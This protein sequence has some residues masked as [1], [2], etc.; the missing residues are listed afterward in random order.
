MG[1]KYNIHTIQ[2]K[3]TKR[4]GVN[5]HVPITTRSKT[6]WDHAP[7]LVSSPL[8]EVLN[9]NIRPPI[10]IQNGRNKQT[11]DTYAFT[12][13]IVPLVLEETCFVGYTFEYKWKTKQNA[14]SRKRNTDHTSKN[15]AKAHPIN[16]FGPSTDV[17]AIQF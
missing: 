4:N 14:Q 15:Q 17:A 12:F 3:Q 11:F 8:L 7:G 2:P 16:K 1:S 10:T 6:P 13:D 9:D 5:I